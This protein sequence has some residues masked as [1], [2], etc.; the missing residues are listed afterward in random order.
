MANVNKGTET[1][2]NEPLEG[3]VEGEITAAARGVFNSVKSMMTNTAI[4]M[5]SSASGISGS[6]Y[7]GIRN[8]CGANITHIDLDRPLT[9]LSG[10]K[11]G[12]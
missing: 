2:Y 6:A 1:F 7:I 8:A 3:L 4:A 12:V 10:I 5:S 9:I 11:Q